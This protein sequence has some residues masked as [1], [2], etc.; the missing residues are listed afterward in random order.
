[1]ITHSQKKSEKLKAV[2]SGHQE[3]AALDK[4]VS[5]E[6]TKNG[7]LERKLE[8]LEHERT[9]E[10]WL[11]KNDLRNLEKAN[12]ELQKQLEEQR[13]TYQ[14]QLK[15]QR[16]VHQGKPLL[17]SSTCIYQFILDSEK[18]FATE[19]RKTL[20]YK[21]ELLTDVKNLLYRHTDDVERL[22]KVIGDTEQQF[23]N[24]LQQVKTLG[25]KD[26]QRQKELEDL[27]GAAP[28]LVDMVDPPKEVKASQWPLLER[29]REAPKKVLKFLSEAPVACVSNTLSLVKSFLLDAQLQGM[30]A[31]CTEEQF[32]EYLREARPV[33]EQIV[34]SVLQD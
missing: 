28:E 17:P 4:C 13:K 18:L 11:L 12:S 9:R 19:L 14:E 32:D 10:T 5:E 15:E 1:V 2:V 6:I 16:K 34:Q 3:L 8:M 30:A 29:L 27:K 26:E 31:D 23:A 22:Q 33:S 7:L 24:C 21:E 25:E 20:M